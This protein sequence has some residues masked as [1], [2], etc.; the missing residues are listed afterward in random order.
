MKGKF[1]FFH[2]VTVFNQNYAILAFYW[3]ITMKWFHDIFLVVDCIFT[4]FLL[5]WW[6]QP[7][8]FFSRN[9]SLIIQGCSNFNLKL[10]LLSKWH[11][12]SKIQFHIW[13]KAI[14]ISTNYLVC[15]KPTTTKYGHNRGVVLISYLN[16][17]GEK[18]SDFSL[19]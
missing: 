17:L 15:Q 4:I 16:F 12:G 10:N 1:F 14:T 18:R 19:R 6:K 13:K 2:P 11:M 7:N 5:E 9:Y 3:N 8:T